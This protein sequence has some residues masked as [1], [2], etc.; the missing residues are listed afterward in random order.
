MAATNRHTI[1][2][3]QTALQ[4]RGSFTVVRG[5]KVRR[6]SAGI[7]L[8][9]LQVELDAIE[10]ITAKLKG[11]EVLTAVEQSRLRVASLRIRDVRGVLRV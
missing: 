6:S 9:C 2:S 3:H 5:G 8:D 1:E 4:R 11:G 10:A 7:A